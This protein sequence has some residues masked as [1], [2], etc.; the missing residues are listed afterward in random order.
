MPTTRKSK[1]IV[2]IWH[3]ADKGKTETLR[4]LAKL[5]LQTYPQ[6]TILNS[7]PPAIPMKGAGDFRVVVSINGRV[8]AV[9]SQGDPK[10][11]LLGRLQDLVNNFNADVIF[12]STR[13]KGDTVVAVDNLATQN[14]FETIWTSTYQ[15]DTHQKTANRLKAEHILDLVIKLSIL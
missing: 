2:A 5:I 14:G 7:V 4:E 9:E 11:N 6:H 12:C 1:V 3:R 13:T 8:V 15:T 10:T